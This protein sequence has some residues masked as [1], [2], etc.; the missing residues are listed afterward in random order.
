MAALAAGI[1]VSNLPTAT[2][3][4]VTPNAAAAPPLFLTSGEGLI[5]Q[6][7][8]GREGGFAGFA[9]TI[10]AYHAT[11]KGTSVPDL[12]VLQ[13]NAADLTALGSLLAGH[14]SVSYVEP[15]GQ[16]QITGATP[17]DPYYINSDQPNLNGPNGINAPGAWAVETGSPS[18][19]VAV[20]DTGINYNH[21]DLYQ[22]IWIN[23]AEI[24][25]QWYAKSSDGTYDK[26]VHKSDVQTATSGVITFGDL[27]NPVNAGLVT[28]NNG[29]GVIDAG[30][31]LTPY[32]QGGWDNN[33]ADTQDGDTTHPDDFFGWNFVA[34]NN[35]PLDDN[36]HGSNVSGILGAAGNNGIG[37]TGVDWQAQ[38]IAVK[39]FDSSGFGTIS[40][41]VAGINYAAL[42]G[43]RVSNNSWA[44]RAPSSALKT[45]VD[46]AAT[47]TYGTGQ[48][49]GMVFAAAA[50]N[51]SNP[52]A[53]YPAA[54]STS[55]SNIIS[56]A[57]TDSS[58]ILASFSNYGS[59]TV[60]VAAPGTGIV[61]AAGSG[62]GYTV[63]SGT[64]QATPQAAGVAALLLQENPSWSATQVVNQ[65][66]NTVTPDANLTGKIKYAGIINAGAALQEVNLSGAFN[67]AGIVADGS[68]FASTGGL[69]GGGHALSSNLLGSSVVS[70]GN[71]FNL[72][73]L[74]G[75]D[76]VSAS[77]QVIAL[78][79]AANFTTLN[80]LALGIN[81]NQANQTFT[82]KY[83]DG[84]TQTFTQSVSDWFTPSNNVGESKAVTMTYR[85]L[86]TGATDN[87]TFYVYSYSF[88]NGVPHEWW[89]PS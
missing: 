4:A 62:T 58:G 46:N 15:N 19:T 21:P 48:G 47:Q 7:R 18:V 31:L 78:P 14:A 37:L 17:N 60:D 70:N 1:P 40:N 63:Y 41:V 16:A 49:V 54:Y 74:G 33:G 23:Q 45:A 26:V 61:G 2:N 77:G 89:T 64:S 57:A 73:A 3:S 39:S 11:A 65:I 55:D 10:Q 82:V 27:N 69:D 50:G 44:Y 84:S 12:Y 85:D 75:N 67:N 83:T 52:T 59:T 29:D 8:P 87:R 56:V 34:G 66:E 20:I 13:G 68:T 76:V 22:N 28:D 72:G 79:S 43:A 9:S 88:T 35:N 36:G 42:H 81:G 24:P 51:F 80:F 25:S 71:T 6:L 86:Y 32:T 30:D 38:L 5:V 53:D